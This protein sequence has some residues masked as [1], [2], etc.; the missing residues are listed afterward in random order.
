[1]SDLGKTRRKKN[2]VKIKKRTNKKHYNINLKK[3]HKNKTKRRKIK[4]GNALLN[5]NLT[6]YLNDFFLQNQI[7]S[8][9]IWDLPTNMEC[10][11]IHGKFLTGYDQSLE[12]YRNL[13]SDELL[14]YMSMSIKEQELNIQKMPKFNCSQVVLGTMEDLTQYIA[15]N[16]TKLENNE[17]VPFSILQTANWNE[18]TNIAFVYCA[19][20]GQL[21]NSDCKYPIRILLPKNMNRLIN[22]EGNA[23]VTL[24]EL[25]FVDNLVNKTDQIIKILKTDDSYD[26]DILFV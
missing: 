8:C 23:R 13:H 15:Y 14:K 18:K 12:M 7:G 9:P 6:E 21:G 16:N 20:Y 26:Y 5:F 4:G 1:M 3:S 24:K 10:K 22:K 19:Y 11:Q 2:K 25:C 17:K